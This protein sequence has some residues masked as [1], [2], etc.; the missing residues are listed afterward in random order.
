MYYKGLKKYFKGQLKK[1]AKEF[2]RAGQE[3]LYTGDLNK[4]KEAYYNAGK[5][6]YEYRRARN[7]DSLSEHYVD[8]VPALVYFK[9]ADAKEEFFRLIE[10]LRK[11]ERFRKTQNIKNSALI[12]FVS[13]LES[14]DVRDVLNE[15]DELVKIWNESPKR[16]KRKLMGVYILMQIARNILFNRREVVKSLWLRYESEIYKVYADLFELLRLMIHSF[17]ESR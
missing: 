17:L 5:A 3:Y 11:L 6:L 12:L 1:A 2:C 7:S 8:L 16:T 9:F 4:A 15:I 10:K 14:Y 13:A